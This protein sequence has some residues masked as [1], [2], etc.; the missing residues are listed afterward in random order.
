MCENVVCRGGLWPPVR[1]CTIFAGGHRPPLQTHNE[2]NLNQY[3]TPVSAKKEQI[4]NFI[5]QKFRLLR[6]IS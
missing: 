3:T 2:H 5:E 1:Y 4:V 6:Y